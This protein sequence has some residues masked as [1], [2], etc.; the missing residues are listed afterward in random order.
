M[1]D[2]PQISMSSFLTIPL[3]EMYKYCQYHQL[4]IPREAKATYDL[5]WKFL[6]DHPDHSI[7]SVYLNDFVTAYGLQGRIIQKSLASSI[8]LGS[9]KELLGL[10]R[11]LGLFKVNKDKIIRILSYLNLLDHDMSLFDLLPQDTLKLIGSHLDCLSLGSFGMISRRFHQLLG[12]TGIIIELLRFETQKRTRLDLSNYSHRQ[13]GIVYRA[14]NRKLNIAAGGHH[15]LVLIE[16]HGKEPLVLDSRVRLLG[17]GSNFFGQICTGDLSAVIIPTLIKGS[18]IMCEITS[19]SAGMHHSLVVGHKGQVWGFGQNSLGELGLGDRAN[20]QTPTLIHNDLLSDIDPLRSERVVAISAGSHHSLFLNSQ[21]QVFSCGSNEHGQL[22]LMDLYNQDIPTLIEK[23]KTIKM[24]AISA[25]GF[26]SL[27]LDDQGQVYSCGSNEEGQ[28]GLGNSGSL[29][30]ESPDAKAFGDIE[31]QPYL[32]LIKTPIGKAVAISAGNSHSLILNSEGQVFS[33]GYGA[34]GQLGLGDLERRLIP[35]L[36]EAPW[37]GLIIAIS[38]GGGYSLILNSQ[39]QVFGFGNNVGTTQNPRVENNLIL[40]TRLEVPGTDPI[41]EISVGYFHS[42]ISDSR[43][44]IFS[45]GS[46]RYGQLGVGNGKEKL[47]PTLIE[48]FS[49]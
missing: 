23:T 31:D 20:R 35:T 47:A 18:E 25:G 4:E 13:L 45:F 12:I 22:G 37:L 29:D 36:I 19:I 44:R 15:S 1:I 38:A 2:T 42:L 27:F 17:M 33:F 49:I 16:C 8:I 34:Y 6:F 3:D 28:L 32:R 41:T 43:G 30:P 21:G 46:N 9:E 40:P 14:V 26:H 5:V 11:S 48:G 7:H 10:A 24:V 39:G